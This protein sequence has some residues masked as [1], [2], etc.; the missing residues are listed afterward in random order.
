MKKEY[1]MIGGI[2]VLAVVVMNTL[3]G[4]GLIQMVPVAGPL[5]ANAWAK[6]L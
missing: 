1:L 6:G 5:V 3:V 4:R 2:A